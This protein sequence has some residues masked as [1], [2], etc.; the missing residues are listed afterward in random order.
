MAETGGQEEPK[1][2]TLCKNDLAKS[3]FHDMT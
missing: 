2:K 3:I 1:H